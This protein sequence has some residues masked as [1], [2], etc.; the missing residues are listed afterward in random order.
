M[1][2]I[3]IW[4]AEYSGKKR[5]SEVG[6]IR[7]LDFIKRLGLATLDD[8]NFC[9]LILGVILTQRGT[10]DTKYSLRL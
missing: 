8:V 6:V 9:S 10:K 7:Y 4:F 2:A 3:Y 5:K 1:E